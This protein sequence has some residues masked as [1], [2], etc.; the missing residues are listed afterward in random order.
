MTG[1]TRHGN[2]GRG[3][4]RHAGSLWAQLYAVLPAGLCRPHR[5][6]LHRASALAAA[7][8]LAIALVS[9]TSGTE[10]MS[11]TAVNS[12]GDVAAATTCGAEVTPISEP[13]RQ[14]NLVL[15][16]SGSMFVDSQGAPS[17]LWSI[18]KYSLEVF[19]ALISSNDTLNVFPMSE[20]TPDAPAE[21][22]LSL[23]GTIPAE[24]R[25]AGVHDLVLNGRST[26]WRSVTAAA[27]N[28]LRSSSPVRWLVVLTDGQFV[29][30]TEQ[31]EPD[32]VLGLLDELAAQGVSI[33]FMSI[34]REA[35]V[36]PAGEGRIVAEVQ[37]TGQLLSA[38]TGF[39]N[40][41][42]E[43]S[44]V[45]GLDASG[46][47]TTDIPMSE[48]V[49]FAQGDDV[50]IGDASTTEGAVPPSG[51]VPVSWTPNKDVEVRSPADP[52]T[53]LTIR[54]V[55]DESLEGLL[56]SYS[57]IPAGSITFDISNA[58]QVD[59]F[60]KPDVE[61]GYFITDADGLD[62]GNVLAPDTPYTLNYSFM[63]ASC[64]PVA[65]ELLSPVLYTAEILRDGEV[66]QAD[67]PP[68][69]SIQLPS[70]DY[71]LR[72][73]ATYRGGNAA[74]VIPLIVT[75]QS[76]GLEY[77]VSQMAEYPPTPEGIPFRLSVSTEGTNLVRPPTQEE[78]AALDPSAVAFNSTSDLEFQFVKGSRPGE[79]TILVRAPG[80]DIYAATTG[81][82]SVTVTPADQGALRGQTSAPVRFTVIDDISA[83]DRFMHWFWTVGI[84]ILVAI[85]LVILALG[86]LL[87]KR[88]PRRLKKRP[89][90]EGIP[91]VIG[92]QRLNGRGA[93]Q[94]NGFRRILPFV[95]D[96][97]TLKYVPAGTMGFR[98]MQVKAGPRKMLRLT[99][100]K[101]IAKQSNVQVNGSPLDESTMK[102]PMFGAS[103]MITADTPQ[104]SFE[105]TPSQ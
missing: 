29:D 79:A 100:W 61:F 98:P 70:A 91:R 22:T 94:V 26:P 25:V 80:G 64:V 30:G 57:S 20:Y 56:A 33:A 52:D 78:W 89:T 103:A 69:E 85:A 59:V 42:F 46:S 27:E 83:F 39:A 84:W 87:K 88:F 13:Q 36:L 102:E 49:V 53:I 47:W 43:R 95:A 28:I 10:T 62:V 38:M 32:V 8:F 75:T 2:Y 19:A 71:E 54:P 17:T 77:F 105:M 41:I 4:Y 96:T 76:S 3:N 58:S 67:I 51:V 14:I 90:I 74:A 16:E 40:T 63:D 31:V 37:D 48:V 5:S 7:P 18:A 82:I 1:E 24:D 97:G 99:N 45:T 11:G 50:A 21:P 86:Y 44:V 104:M 81:E 93:F 12:A 65:S 9:C 23:P 6:R 66:L 92:Q 15:D 55:A 101:D 34:G 73:S 60:Y 72:V 68:G 35:V